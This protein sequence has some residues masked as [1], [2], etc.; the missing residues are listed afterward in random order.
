[1]CPSAARL[2]LHSIELVCGGGAEVT[3]RGVGQ[4]LSNGTRYGYKT[5]SSAI[6]QSNSLCCFQNLER[7]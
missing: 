7:N 3:K 4:F 5:Y 6:S 1:M 2:Y